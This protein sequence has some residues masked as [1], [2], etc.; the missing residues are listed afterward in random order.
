MS[1][2]VA[3]T[4]SKTATDEGT[5]DLATKKVIIFLATS[6]YYTFS[7]LKLV[8]AAIAYFQLGEDAVGERIRRGKVESVLTFTATFL[9]A[10]TNP[11]TGKTT[12]S[13]HTDVCER[14]LNECWQN[15]DVSN[16][17]SL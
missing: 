14:R 3:T 13:E 16:E 7:L 12:Y 9:F 15:F 10:Q 5:R 8:G 17:V 11:P 2:F 6:S 4:C 1:G